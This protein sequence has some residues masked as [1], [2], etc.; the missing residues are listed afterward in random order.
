[1]VAVHRITVRVTKNQLER[2]KLNAQANG[3]VNLSDYIRCLALER[4][5]SVEKMLYEL[6][7]KLLPEKASHKPSRVD[8]PLTRFM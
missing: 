1:M 7:N 8:K 6:Y 2:V 4:D 3:Y 5:I